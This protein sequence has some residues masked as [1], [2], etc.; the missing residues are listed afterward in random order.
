LKFCVL[1]HLELPPHGQGLLH[2]IQLLEVSPYIKM[3]FTLHEL[4]SFGESV[5]IV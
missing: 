4:V 2:W 1:L 5:E 3:S